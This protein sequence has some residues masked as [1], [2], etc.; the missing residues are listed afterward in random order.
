MHAGDR[1]QRQRLKVIRENLRTHVGYTPLFRG[2]SLFFRPTTTA[3]AILCII[4]M[5]RVHSTRAR[6]SG[7]I[8]L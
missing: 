1:R 2:G 6:K 3:T 4:L 8:I 7:P 5:L